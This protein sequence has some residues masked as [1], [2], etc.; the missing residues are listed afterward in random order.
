VG[1]ARQS[2]N[3]KGPVS[4]YR[5]KHNN[6]ALSNLQSCRMKICAKKQDSRR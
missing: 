2:R 6:P 5:R 1:T 4:V 3:H